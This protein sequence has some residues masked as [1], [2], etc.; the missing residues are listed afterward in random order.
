VSTRIIAGLVGLGIVLPS[1]IFGGLPA[2]ILLV[3]LVMLI[4]C[5]EYAGLT[6]NDPP[7]DPKEE[8]PHPLRSPLRD[9]VV[10]SLLSLS[11]FATFFYGQPSWHL[12][13]LAAGGLVALIWSLFSVPVT[14]R[15]AR[16]AIAMAGGLVYLP[17]LLSFVPV[18]YDREQ[19][20]WWMLYLFAG[21]WMGDTGAYFAGRFLG[22]HKMFPR[23]S[24]KKTW[25]GFF[26]GL[27]AAVASAAIFK[28]L[29]LPDLPWHHAIICA[30][31]L[32]LFGVVG[33][34]VE[35]MMKRS[36]QVKDSGTIM[37]GHGGILDRIDSLLFTAPVLVLYLSA[38]GLG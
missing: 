27:I 26:G 29:G 7:G 12:P 14:E 13:A 10:F 17:L 3:V 9:Q 21:T 16:Q 25:E 24:P 36:Y 20:I 33:D 34:L 4:A 30:A 28:A 11:L 22:S 32:D 19:G 37:P 5:H 38:F 8:R 18:V 1:I 6:F 23:V 35:S 15:G 31:I 2:V